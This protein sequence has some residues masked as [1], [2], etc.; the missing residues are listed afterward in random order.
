MLGVAAA[1]LAGVDEPIPLAPSHVKRGDFARAR[2][3]LLDKGHDGESVA[4]RAFELEPGFLTARAVSRIAALG[5]DSLKLEL[6][7]VTINCLAIV[8]FEMFDVN[9]F[10]RA[11]GQQVL[12]CALALP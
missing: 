3:E 5:N 7:C 6:A 4:L 9:D 10:G 8:H 12:Q 1:R 11:I 2:A